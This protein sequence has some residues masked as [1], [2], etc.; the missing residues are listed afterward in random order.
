MH[1]LSLP[2]H[3]PCTRSHALHSFWECINSASDRICLIASIHT[4]TH[5]ISQHK[6]NKR[7]HCQSETTK[8]DNKKMLIL[9]LVRFRPFVGLIFAFFSGLCCCLLLFFFLSPFA[10]AQTQPTTKSILFVLLYL[11]RMCLLSPYPFR[12]VDFG[13]P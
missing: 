12:A 1:S 2:L 13:S 3:T 4:H 6:Q 9:T 7:V 10:S 5:G 8:K 11:T